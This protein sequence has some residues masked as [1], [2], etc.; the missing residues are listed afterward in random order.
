MSTLN[1]VV[2]A[3]SNFRQL[4]ASDLHGLSKPALQDIVVAQ[5]DKWSASAH[6]KFTAKTNKTT[7]R[8]ALLDPE[9]GFTIGISEPVE[10]N[11]SEGKDEEGTATVSEAAEIDSNEPDD[12]RA[13]PS[14]PSVRGSPN[15]DQAVAAPGASPAL[16]D[17]SLGFPSDDR[18]P[19]PVQS[20]DV[21]W[22]A[23]E[24]PTTTGGAAIELNESS[25]FML[26]APTDPNEPAGPNYGL[27]ELDPID[28]A[29]YTP[30]GMGQGHLF[31]GSNLGLPL[32]F[33]ISDC[34]MT[35]LLGNDNTFT[36]ASDQPPSTFMDSAKL[37]YPTTTTSCGTSQAPSTG[38]QDCS[39]AVGVKPGR[40]CD[41]ARHLH[42]YEM[43]LIDG[44]YRKIPKDIIKR[45]LSVGTTWL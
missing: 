38:Q 20:N 23:T 39:T 12:R 29:S 9:L 8:A 1:T 3:K 4:R 19:L 16:P 5:K 6:G 15:K 27:D 44:V 25:A 33:N 32:E 28:P 43:R 41:P 21:M 17:P 35:D 42:A 34:K 31:S 26:D 14:Y 10:P 7:M 45:S 11:L 36:D 37:G 40:S 30:L 22:A 18:R 13:V 2:D 24:G